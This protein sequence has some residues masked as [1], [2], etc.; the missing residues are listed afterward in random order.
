MADDPIQ[1]QEQQQSAPQT[2]TNT[3]PNVQSDAQ[4]GAAPALQPAAKKS[5]S[6][7]AVAGLVLGL[8]AL[9]SCWIPFFN[10]VTT[11]LAILGLVFAIIGIVAT[12]PAKPKGG[13]G[14]AIAGTVLCAIS[15]VVFMAMYG[16]AAASVGAAASDDSSSTQVSATSDSGSDSDADADTSADTSAGANSDTDA[17]SQDC[18]IV[19]KSCKPG[20]DYKGDKTAVITL[21]WTN[22]GDKTSAFYT[23]YTYSA[24]VDGEEADRP[25][26]SGDGWYED[27]TKIKPGKTKTIKL[28]YAWDGKSDVD[29][30]VNEWFH[31]DPVLSQT[32]KVK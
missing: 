10:V 20:T 26:A 7:L 30:E 4:A 25:I 17:D 24:Y 23:A 29:F 31:S 8:I 13:C 3:Q 9:L 19:V 6:G 2:Q 1:A 21:E 11:P 15:L 32:L 14:I 16:G 27:Q 18:G 5:T 22:T 12:A 28:M